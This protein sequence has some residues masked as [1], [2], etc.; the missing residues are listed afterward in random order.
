MS[1]RPGAPERVTLSAE[2]T[3]FLIEFSIALHRTLMYPEGHPS[4]E[5]S[6]AGVV[7]RLAV[8]LADRPTV[9]IGVARRQLVIE[10]VATDS[11]HPV[12]R[13]LAEKFHKQHIG[14][15]VFERGVSAAELADMMSTVA[16]QAERGE[17]PLGLDNPE[18]LRSWKGVRLF[19]LTY[20]QLEMVGEADEQDED[21]KDR[22]AATRAAQLWIGLARAALAT[23][24][25]AEPPSTDAL[26]VAQAIN[27]HPQ[28]VAYDQVVVGYLLQ[29]AQEL[30]E[31]GGAGAAAVRR[32]MS[33]LIGSLEPETLKRLVEMG[34]DIGQRRQFVL[35][36]TEGLAV[37]AVIDVMR[38]AAESSG[39]N[40]SSSLMRM[41]SKLSMFAE[42][43][44]TPMQVQADTAL[45]E[46]VRDL[47]KD[48]ELSDPNPDA[49]TH[50][51]QSISRVATGA[52]SGTT[53][54]L[55]EPL[56]IVQM[57]LETDA[58]GVPLWRAVKE[59]EESGELG[60]LLVTLKSVPEDG[61][62]AT[63]LWDYFATENKVRE[64]LSRPQLDFAIVSMLLDRL[65]KDRVI[66]M[67]LQT[68]VEAEQRSTRMAIFRRLVSLGDVAVPALVARLSDERWY[69]QRNMLAI[70]G[71]M[72]HVPK[73]FS[74]A[75]LARHD[76][77]RVRRE[78]YNLW[79]RMPAERER[80]IVSALAE[81]DER[82]VRLAVQAAQHGVPDAAVPLI[83]G[84]LTENV[85]ADLRLQL[86]R[87]LGHVRNP[88]AVDVLLKF[89]VAGR[90]LLG[91]VK[92]ADKSPLMLTALTTLA[93]NWAN[94]AR[95]RPALDRAARSKDPDVIR[96]LR[97]ESKS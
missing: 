65:P 74:P 77:V 19:P 52:H 27:E 24:S 83:G 54:Y 25:A 1:H 9:S 42:Q 94:D 20:D 67:L 92:L 81:P 88:L 55:P 17:R 89:V 41:L 66:E 21:E 37:D 76:D 16:L 90:A 26:V 63:V 60:L 11:R 79:L 38:A 10:G 18:R 12:L 68:L 48:W 59:M 22:E 34:G 47:I 13:S 85:P 91:G 40:V 14:A 53:R 75:E 28:A 46:Q 44:S 84:R 61:L 86:V 97:T 6:A 2:L 7:Q 70:M 87:L 33:R 56:R 15:V 64:L 71:E 51:L 32:R 8:L 62:V 23:E 43:G 4:Q 31:E 58:V 49:Y 82:I 69:V 3:E 5:K 30:K 80:A 93:S 96:A 73:T 36:A 29:L 72:Q 95:V 57:A 78:A 45:R 35:D 50:A 39:Q